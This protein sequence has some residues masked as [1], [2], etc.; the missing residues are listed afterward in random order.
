VDELG[1]AALGADRCAALLEVEV[2]DVEREDLAARTRMRRR[3]RARVTAPPRITARSPA[4]GLPAA[5][6]P[7]RAL[8]AVPGPPVVEVWHGGSAV[9][10][11]V[12]PAMRVRDL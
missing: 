7:P 8:A 3:S 12:E 10:F 6:S 4:A 11:E 1:V 5:G 9:A 2:L